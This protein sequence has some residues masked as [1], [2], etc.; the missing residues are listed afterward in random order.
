MTMTFA[1]L[2]AEVLLWVIDAPLAVQSLV[3]RFVN[4][5]IRKIQ[6][7]HDFKFMEAEVNFVTASSTRTLGARPDDWKKPRNA[8]P[9][10]V[11]NLGRTRELN[12]ASTQG[13]AKAR[14]GDNM[15]LNFGSPRLIVEVENVDNTGTFF[16]YPFSD[17]LSDYPDGQYRVYFPYWKFLP[18][19]VNPTDHNWLS[20]NAE[21]A[22]IYQAVA[23]AFYANEDEQRAAIWDAKASKELKDAILLDKERR[24]AETASFTPHL[25]ARMPHVQE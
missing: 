3:P 22:V 18:E 4:R 12:Y 6:W 1:D 9:Y 19:L 16:L 21:Q 13:E 15:S 2:Q 23:D 11:E 8:K 10:L 17:G 20:D 24:V 7:K 25:G 5:S 14:F